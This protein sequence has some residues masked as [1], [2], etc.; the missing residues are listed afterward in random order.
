M[1]LFMWIAAADSSLFWNQFYII[2]SCKFGWPSI[3]CI[4]AFIR[5]D[6]Y[7]RVESVRTFVRFSTFWEVFWI[8]LSLTLNIFVC[9][10][11]VLMIIH[12]FK[13][14]S[15]RVNYYVIIAVILGIFVAGFN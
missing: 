7:N 3:N 6:Y 2:Y 9:I 10:D 1:K 14:Q 8:Q 5:P 11:L 13:D 15:A 12:P 4:V